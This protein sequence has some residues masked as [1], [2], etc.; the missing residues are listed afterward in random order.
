MERA[1]R[2]GRARGN[3]RFIQDNLLVNVRLIGAERPLSAVAMTTY[4]SDTDR[5]NAVQQTIKRSGN[6][7]SDSAAVRVA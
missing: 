2:K 4:G 7:P 1:N 3:R 5:P 6:R